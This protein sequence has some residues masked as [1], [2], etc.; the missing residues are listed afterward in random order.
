[1]SLPEL[2]D[3]PALRRAVAE[4]LEQV[5]DTRHHFERPDGAIPA[6]CVSSRLKLNRMTGYGSAG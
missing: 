2:P 6:A 4:C 3:T 1:M 5:P